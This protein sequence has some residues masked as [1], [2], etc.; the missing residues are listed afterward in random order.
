MSKSNREFLG[1]WISK[2]IWLTKELTLLEK[3]LFVEIIS[4]NNK[5]KG[6]WA[7]NAY[8]AKFF[9]LSASRVSHVIASLIKK[10]FIVATYKD[11][12]QRTIRPLR[13]HLTPLAEIAF[14]PCENSQH[15]NTVS[16]TTNTT[17]SIKLEDL[18]PE[19][20]PW[21]EQKKKR[22][23]TL[24]SKEATELT[25]HLYKSILNRLPDMLKPN[26]NTW[27]LEMDRIIKLDGRTVEKIRSVIDY[28][29]R[30]NF[31]S[32]VILSPE[33]LRKSFDKIA[34]KLSAGAPVK[35]KTP[36]GKDGLT[37]RQRYFNSKKN[38]RNGTTP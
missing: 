2:E 15:N 19:T 24:V 21:P 22:R 17:S 23:K 8:F 25:E 20:A 30:D 38:G 12:Q 36:V 33:S 10:K 11:G 31:W 27:S 35:H 7:N 26:K 13:K 1:I 3:V 29:S 18:E 4:L 5:A 16:N 14:D 6:C 32:S 9:G 28:V 37:P 34:I